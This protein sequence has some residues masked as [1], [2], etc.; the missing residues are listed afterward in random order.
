[1][2]QQGKECQWLAA[3]STHKACFAHGSTAGNSASNLDSWI[4][5]LQKKTVHSRYSVCANLL[6]KLQETII[7]INNRLDNVGKKS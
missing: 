7:L 4:R 1:M 2:Y 3:G 5:E 6:Q